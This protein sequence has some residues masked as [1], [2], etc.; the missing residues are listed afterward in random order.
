MRRARTRAAAAMLRSAARNAAVRVQ[1]AREQA[2]F[3]RDTLLPLR[4]RVV[5]ET[6]RQYNAMNATVFALLSAKR[7]HIDGGRAYVEA[8]RDYWMA[9]A[10]LDQLLAGRLPRGAA[11]LGPNDGPAMG[12]TSAGAPH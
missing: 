2:L 4:E 12:S 9:R 7:D 1:A 6:L 11:A 10:E 8:L 3:H 5:D